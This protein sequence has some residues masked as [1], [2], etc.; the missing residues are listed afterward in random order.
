[1]T[2]WI[3]KATA[4]DAKAI[5]ALYDSVRDCDFCAWNDHYPTMQEIEFDLSRD[6][7]FVMK[8]SG[9]RI[10]AAVSLDLDENVEQLE[11]WSR[12]LLPG[13]ELSRLAVAR[14]MQNH[15]IART[16]LLYGMDVLKT[17][18]MKSAHFLVAKTNKIAL[19]SYAHLNCSVVGE[20]ELYESEYLCYEKAL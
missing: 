16:M 7:L 10:V 15:G 9:G 3:T 17:R 6:S 4:E 2:T 11:C 13:G 8:E 18:G 20:C 5:L 19:L 1:M 12:E 14:D